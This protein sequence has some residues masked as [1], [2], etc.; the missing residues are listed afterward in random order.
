MA[1]FDQ[2]PP[3]VRA[4]YANAVEDW[5]VGRAFRAWKSGRVRPSQLIDTVT[6]SDAAELAKREAQR[7]AARGPYR[8][9]VPDPEPM[10]RRKNA[11]KK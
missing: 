10:T 3:T 9:N 4:A 11:R 5:H 1:M 8:G 2:L 7:R 6:R